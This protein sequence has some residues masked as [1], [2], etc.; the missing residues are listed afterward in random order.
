MDKWSRRYMA[1]QVLERAAETDVE[2][3]VPDGEEC[4]AE[5]RRV[6][7]LLK[8]DARPEC[9]LERRV[10]PLVRGAGTALRR[11]EHCRRKTL[12]TGEF[13]AH[14]GAQFSQTAGGDS[15]ALQELECDIA[16][17]STITLGM[18]GTVFHQ[19]ARDEDE[20]GV[21][22]RSDGISFSRLESSRF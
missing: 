15:P 8:I 5:Q 9:L 12:P 19:S 22:R 10:N 2:T 7:M 1:M 4:A 21:H 14:G 3:F 6:R 18:I 17:G 16:G 20:E 13:P 11:A